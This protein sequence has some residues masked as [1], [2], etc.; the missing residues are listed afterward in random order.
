[1]N[2]SKDL[3]VNT[4]TFK[5]C[6]KCNVSKSLDLFGLIKKK[7]RSQCKDC[8]NEYS[9]NYRKKNPEKIRI[10]NTIMQIEKKY[11]IILIT[12]KLQ[13]PPLFRNI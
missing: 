4:V 3:K 8:V 11:T 1:M 2:N 13:L 7:P 5:I 9:R 6:S 12:L 10:T